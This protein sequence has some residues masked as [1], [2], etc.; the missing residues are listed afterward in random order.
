MLMRG[1]KRFK[2]LKIAGGAL[3]GWQV[4]KLWQSSREGGE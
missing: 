1:G 4:Y 2:L 3:V